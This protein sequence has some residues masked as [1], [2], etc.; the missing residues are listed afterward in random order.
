MTRKTSPQPRD[1]RA[2]GL[3]GPARQVH[4]AV[5]AAFARTGQPP[6][7]D[8]LGQLARSLGAS[9]DRRVSVSEVVCTSIRSLLHAGRSAGLRIR[10]HGWLKPCA[11]PRGRP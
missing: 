8:E 6:A 9:P 3:T 11:H 5:L 7:L 10:L 4:Q 1:C 2:E